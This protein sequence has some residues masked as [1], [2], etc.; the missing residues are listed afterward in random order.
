MNGTTIHIGQNL[1]NE[2]KQNK[3]TKKQK[4]IPLF[5]T[6]NLKILIINTGI[7]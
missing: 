6:K 5:K 1:K 3:K 2:A 4:L 7:F